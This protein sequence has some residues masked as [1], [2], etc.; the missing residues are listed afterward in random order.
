MLAHETYDVNHCQTTIVEFRDG[1]PNFFCFWGVSIYFERIVEVPW[2][3]VWKTLKF[4]IFSGFPTLG[5]MRFSSDGRQLGICFQKPNKQQNLKFGGN[6]QN[7]PLFGR[8]TSTVETRVRLSLLTQFINYQV[9]EVGNLRQLQYW[10]R[11]S[12]Q[13]HGPRKPGIVL[14]TI[15]NKSKHGDSPMLDFGMT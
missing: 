2:H 5:I 4:W 11:A 12:I 13:G 7:I 9:H 3:T 1:T 8:S 10:E 6:W 15:S 14:N